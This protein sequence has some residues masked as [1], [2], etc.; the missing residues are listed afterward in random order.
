MEKR[1]R[2]RSTRDF[3]KVYREKN[4]LYNREFTIYMRKNDLG[5]PRFGFSISK[6][7]GKANV[8]NLLK[9]RLREI[10]RLNRH[11]FDKDYDYVIIP[12]PKTRDMEYKDLEKSLL[13]CYMRS[14]KSKR[15]KK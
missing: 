11:V 10:I 7:I 8:R 1:D 5:Y 9:R 4:S 14:K 3:Q 2:L 13:H 12:R 15:K 6:K